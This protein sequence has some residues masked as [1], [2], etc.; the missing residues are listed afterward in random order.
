MWTMHSRSSRARRSNTN[1]RT[2]EVP[3]SSESTS[4]GFASATPM[5]SGS[6]SIPPRACAVTIRTEGIL[7]PIIVIVVLVL[8][9]VLVIGAYNRLVTL[10]QR[11]NEAYSDI[12]VQLK[13]RHDLI[14]NL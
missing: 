10:R 5:A 3:M 1:A 8:L 9:A 11:V 6:L 12:D 4:G 2:P 13:R 14:P 7:E